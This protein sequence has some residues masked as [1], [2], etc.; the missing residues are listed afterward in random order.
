MHIFLYSF[1]KFSVKASL[2]SAYGLEGLRSII[3]SH[4]RLP[5]IVRDK[6]LTFLCSDFQEI[7]PS[8]CLGEV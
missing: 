7:T 6:T 8:D 2:V 5:Q 3:L 4:P 1:P